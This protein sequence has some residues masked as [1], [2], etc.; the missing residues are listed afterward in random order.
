MIYGVVCLNAF[1]NPSVYL[2]IGGLVRILIRSEISLLSSDRSTWQCS[3]HDC[4]SFLMVTFLTDKRVD[5][6]EVV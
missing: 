5:K 2:S 6:S 3:G 4:L 1:F